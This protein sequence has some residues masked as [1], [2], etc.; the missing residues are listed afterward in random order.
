MGQAPSGELVVGADTLTAPEPGALA[1]AALG[2][3]VVGLRR[4]VV[5]RRQNSAAG[6]APVSPRT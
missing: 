2:L 5:G 1:L 4:R 3:G 6:A